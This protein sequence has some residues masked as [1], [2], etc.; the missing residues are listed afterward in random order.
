[1]RHSPLVVITRMIANAYDAEMDR[2]GD[3]RRA[4]RG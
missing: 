4:Y 3:P 1:M 2:A